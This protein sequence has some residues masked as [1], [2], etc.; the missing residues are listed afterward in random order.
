MATT[1]A[2]EPVIWQKIKKI[3]EKTLCKGGGECIMWMGSLDKDGYGRKSIKWGPLEKSREEK[4]H[5]LSFMLK[6]KLAKLPHTNECGELMEV[7]HWCHQKSCINS[8][9]LVLENRLSNMSRET[10]RCERVCTLRH[11]PTCIL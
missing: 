11:E 7:S 5:R 3:F 8:D 10:C 4:A 2:V 9:H 1:M 6:Y